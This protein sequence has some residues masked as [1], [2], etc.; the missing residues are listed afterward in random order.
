MTLQESWRSRGPCQGLPHRVAEVRNAERGGRSRISPPLYGDGGEG[1]AEAVG[2]CLQA[3]PE[4][5]Y[6]TEQFTTNTNCFRHPLV[7][8]VS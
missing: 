6:F 3:A 7:I 1:V 8:D 2:F 5:Q 4:H